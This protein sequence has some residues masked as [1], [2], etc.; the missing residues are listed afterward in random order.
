MIDA[1]GM[2]YRAIGTMSPLAWPLAFACG[3]AGSVGPCVAPRFIALAGFTFGVHRTKALAIT[4]AFAG[5]IM[6]AYACL[7]SVVSLLSHVAAFST[8]MYAAIAIALVVYGGAMLLREPKDHAPG[9]GG[10][11]S[12]DCKPHAHSLG[13]VFLL[14]AAS[15]L[16]IS[17]CCTPVALGI[18][19]LAASSGNAVYGSALLAVFALGHALPLLFIGSCSGLRVVRPSL[20]WRTAGATV[21][22]SLLLALGAYYGLLA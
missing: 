6:T 17:P 7:G 20:E 2:T 16:V 8:V 21:A 22:G 10:E 9:C 19:A 5:G 13:G 12:S 15:T 1:V 14:G 3:A 18:L 11:A 4:A